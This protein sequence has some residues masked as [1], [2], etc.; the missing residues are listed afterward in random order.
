LLQE[1]PDDTARCMSCLAGRVSL[2][3]DN[4]RY[5]FHCSA[6]GYVVPCVDYNARAETVR[7]YCTPGWDDD[8]IGK[9]VPAKGYYAPREFAGGCLT[10]SGTVTAITWL[11][12]QSGQLV[13]D[14]GQCE[15][16]GHVVRVSEPQDCA[17]RFR[18]FAPDGSRTPANA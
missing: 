16:C 11:S 9:P 3:P 17:A 2:K 13:H 1:I 5:S 12:S 6:C 10:C 4:G 14:H 18:A 15:R 8:N 7:A